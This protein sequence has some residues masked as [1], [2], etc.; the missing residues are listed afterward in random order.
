MEHKPGLWGWGWEVLSHFGAR[1]AKR[2]TRV[3]SP[4]RKRID[5]IT[6]WHLPVDTENSHTAPNSKFPGFLDRVGTLFLFVD[7]YSLIFN[8]SVL[9]FKTLTREIDV[10]N[11]V[12]SSCPVNQ[13]LLSILDQLAEDW[14]PCSGV[15][16]TLPG[17]GG[18]WP[19][20]RTQQPETPE[21][22]QF[23]SQSKMSQPLCQENPLSCDFVPLVQLK[24]LSP[25]SCFFLMIHLRHHKTLYRSV[26]LIRRGGIRHIAHSDPHP[27]HH[28]SCLPLHIRTEPGATCPI[29]LVVDPCPIDTC[30]SEMPSVPCPIDTCQRLSTGHAK[31]A[32]R[33]A[34]RRDTLLQNAQYRRKRT[35]PVC[36]LAQT[37]TVASCAKTNI[38]LRTLNTRDEEV[39]A[40]GAGHKLPQKHPL[41]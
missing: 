6:G 27:S 14:S 5:A 29:G 8:F 23:R 24:A 11:S 3:W 12:R 16:R 39:F 4:K 13:S 2:W 41:R 30:K 28:T 25:I 21:S 34:A 7:T 18:V 40:H 38:N 17:Q 10:R 20:G 36:V 31:L 33:Q 22:G 15:A 32:I 1:A 35:C 26:R 37:I 9:H 19:F